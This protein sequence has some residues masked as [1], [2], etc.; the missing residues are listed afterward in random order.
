MRQAPVSESVAPHF[1]NSGWETVQKFG[2]EVS[3][4]SSTTISLGHPILLSYNFLT[5]GLEMGG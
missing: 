3:E 2:A 4:P 5:W 1:T